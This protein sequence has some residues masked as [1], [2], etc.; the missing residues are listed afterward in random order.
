[1]VGLD[2]YVHIDSC[3]PGQIHNALPP[4]Q[5]RRPPNMPIIGE[6]S[7][8]LTSTLTYSCNTDAGDPF[9]GYTFPAWATM[10]SDNALDSACKDTR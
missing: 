2:V 3:E 8:R 5:P 6:R 10:T 9:G 7:A 1:M 4:G